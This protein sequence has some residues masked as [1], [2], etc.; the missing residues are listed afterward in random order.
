MLIHVQYTAHICYVF[1]VMF[2]I[3]SLYVLPSN[4]LSKLLAI[5]NVHVTQKYPKISINTHFNNFRLMLLFT[6]YVSIIFHL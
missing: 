2:K 1:C 6:K 3:S 4:P 5:T